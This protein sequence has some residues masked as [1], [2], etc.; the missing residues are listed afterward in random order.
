MVY[1]STILAVAVIVTTVLLLY[2]IPIFG[3][4][5]ED[6]G[7]GLPAPT[8]ITS[9]SIHYTK[10]YD[11]AAS[12][13]NLVEVGTTNR[14]RPADY[15]RAVGPDTALLLKVHRSNFRITGFTEEVPAADLAVLGSRFKIPVV[16]DLGS[17]AVFD[18]AGAGI[19][20]TPT[21]RQALSYNFV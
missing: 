10:L 4:M 9:Y 19:P 2:V 12:G 18:F 6:F 20:G 3:Q 13:A 7:A 17:G 11:L 16:E 15:E 21:I 14:T 8:V 1:P 5:F